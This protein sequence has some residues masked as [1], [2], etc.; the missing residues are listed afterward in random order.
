[1][2]FLAKYQ[3]KE[4]VSFKEDLAR[5]AFSL[6]TGFVIILPI[7]ICLRFVFSV[8][9]PV[10]SD[11]NLAIILVPLGIALSAYLFFKL[12]SVFWPMFKN[13]LKIKF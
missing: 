10:F 2:S 12:R 4:P 5:D 6:I 9:F 7:V 13:K 3:D 11:V 1:M 8:F